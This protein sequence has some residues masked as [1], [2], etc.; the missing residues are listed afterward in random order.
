MLRV[1]I[2]LIQD[3]HGNFLLAQRG[4]GKFLE[5]LWEFPGGKL[6]PGESSRDAL[7]R[8]LKEEIGIE[9]T[10]IEFFTQIK[11]DYPEQTVCLD[12]WLVQAYQG[13]I[14]SREGQVL[15]WVNKAQ[16][17]NLAIPSANEAVVALL[18]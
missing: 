5:G 13:A 12:V 16:L 3:S 7:A 4:Q 14:E 1:A 11:H 9:V 18:P 15:Q 10:D 8:E 2:G 6:E 17:P